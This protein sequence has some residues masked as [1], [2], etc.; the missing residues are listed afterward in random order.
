MNARAACLLAR[1]LFDAIGN[2]EMVRVFGTDALRLMFGAK[3][4]SM[5]AQEFRSIGPKLRAAGYA[6]G[7][8]PETALVR[9]MR[10]A[11]VYGEAT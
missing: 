1:S 5:T 2:N 11:G 6:R 4:G 10:A 3:V 7:S 9:Q 8:V